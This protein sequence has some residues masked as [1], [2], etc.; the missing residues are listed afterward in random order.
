MIIYNADDAALTKLVHES[1]VLSASFGIDNEADFKAEQIQYGQ[2]F[3]TIEI[4]NKFS[5]T[6]SSKMLGQTEQYKTQL[7]GKINVYNTL[8]AVAVIRC[9]GFAQEQIALDLLSYKGVKRAL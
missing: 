4:F 3:T 9:L 8:A 6:V 1:S 2:D 7:P 5:K